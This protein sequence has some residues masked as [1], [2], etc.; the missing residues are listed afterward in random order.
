MNEKVK[1]LGIY[2][3]TFNPI[4]HGHLIMAREAMELLGLDRLV[5]VPNARSP[6]RMNEAL[7]DAELR[8]ELVRAAVEGEAEMEVCDWEVK[9]GGPSYTVET[10]EA[11]AEEH[12]GVELV[13][14]A[15]ADSLESLDRWVR[16]DRILEICRVVI[17]PRPGYSRREAL[18]LLGLRAPALAGKIELLETGRRIEISATE[19]RERIAAGKSIRWLVPEA[20]EKRLLSRERFQARSP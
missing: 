14:L 12:A 13:F 10:L 11:L 18:R 7:A 4:H 2:G 6:L 19:I 9:R 16:V 20:V 17:V 1:R 8:L 5:W 15:G 3:G